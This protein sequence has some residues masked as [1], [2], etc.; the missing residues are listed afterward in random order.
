MK[1]ALCISGQMRTFEECYPKLKENIINVLKPDIFI[2]AWSNAGISTKTNKENNKRF[3][4]KIVTYDI[5]NKLYKP[6]KCIIEKFKPHY[7]DELKNI[8]VPEILKI[9]E[10]RH[11]KGTLPMFYKIYECN[12]LK[13]KW[14]QKNNF[15]Y[16][17][18]IRFRPDLII[19]EKIP[20]K[21]FNHPHIIWFSDY[22]INTSSQVSDKFAISD[23]INMNYYSSVWKYLP[24][25]W[26]NPL[27]NGQ[28][29]NHRVGERLLKYHLKR[30]NLTL[31]P[32]NT[33]CYIKRHNIEKKKFIYFKT[34]TILKNLFKSNKSKF[35]LW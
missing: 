11:Y 35:N 24:K 14:E 12:N 25:Y 10:P 7:T 18:V 4:D 29:K 8:K 31:K 28:Q 23:S 17:I 19:K 15:L 30:Q 21:I 9:K 2:H 16:D 26:K 3:T 1:I 5:L 6:K 33:I 13:K 34:R 27:G 22:K 20:N 32:F